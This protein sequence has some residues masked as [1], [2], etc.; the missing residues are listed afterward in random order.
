MK[1]PK[2]CFN[3]EATTRGKNRG[4]LFFAVISLV[5]I[6][7]VLC[8]S[9]VSAQDVKPDNAVGYYTENGKVTWIIP[10]QGIDVTQLAGAT[11]SMIEKLYPMTP[12]AEAAIVHQVPTSSV[13]I[14]GTLYQAKQISQFNGKRLRFIAGKDGTLNAFT[15]PEKLEQFQTEQYGVVSPQTTTN[16][17]FYKD[18]YYTGQALGLTPGNGLPNLN[19]IGFDNYISSAVATTTGTW[20]YIYDYA[21]Y[22]GDYF[23]MAK[24]SSYPSLTIQG[25]NDRASSIW[26][27][28]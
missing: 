10:G 27:Y 3:N 2:A 7:S 11:P 15:T 1:V 12:Q 22:G 25:W 4:I 14:D 28:Q 18:W 5:L 24:G 9:H 20:S 8:I 23:G 26:V 6:M 13:I 17:V 16:S 21:N 19:Q